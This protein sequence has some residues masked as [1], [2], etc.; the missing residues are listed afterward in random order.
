MTTRRAV[1]ACLLAAFAAA[2]YTVWDK[3]A[4]T[5]LPPLTYFAAYTVL[6]GI[7][8]AALLDRRDVERAWREERATI[9]QVAVLNSGSYM[10]ALLALQTGK[11]SYV[12][13]LRQLSI[14]GGAVLG[15]WLLGEILPRRRQV[16][17]ALVVAGCAMLAFAR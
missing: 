7:A 16:G 10:L 3:R 12:I 6:V 15:A 8:Y 1:I 4:V 14:A 5:L 11:A 9:V 2:C 17:I 13:A